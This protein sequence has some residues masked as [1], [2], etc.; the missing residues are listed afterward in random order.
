M[1]PLLE[2]NILIIEFL[3]PIFCIFSFRQGGKTADIISSRYQYIKYNKS[4]CATSIYGLCIIK[5]RKRRDPS[6]QTKKLTSLY[7]IEYDLWSPFV[8]S[9]LYV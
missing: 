5:G 8:M 6:L 9:N 1:H 2:S 7:I 4:S 3:Q